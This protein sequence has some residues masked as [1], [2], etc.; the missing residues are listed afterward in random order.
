MQ[1]LSLADFRQLSSDGAIVIDCRGL[2]EL[3]L[4]QVPGSVC[5]YFNETFF[6]RL[7]EVTDPDTNLL[8]VADAEQLPAIQ[9]AVRS[10]G[11]GNI[12]GHLSGGFNTWADAALEI[13]IL[14]FIEADELKMDYQFDEFYLIDVRNAEDFAT[15]RLEDAESIPLADLNQMLP[16]LESGNSYYVYGNTAF[17][18]V[19]AGSLFKRNGFE[20]LRIVADDY[21]KIKSVG[22]PL[23]A[24]KKKKSDSTDSKS[25]DN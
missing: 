5:V 14:I 24:V 23:F 16:D 9:K 1:E 4:G 19:T 17:E 3:S 11:A 12:K 2:E 15:E 21:E 6:T 7:A 13:D 10:S 18:A 20:R 8:L 22:I 25:F